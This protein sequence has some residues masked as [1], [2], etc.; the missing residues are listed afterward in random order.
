M[1]TPGIRACITRCSLGD[2]RRAFLHRVRT[3]LTHH[4]TRIKLASDC[5]AATARAYTYVTRYVRYFLK[6][7]RA[8]NVRY[9][10]VY[11]KPTRYKIIK[12]ALRIFAPWFLAFLSSFIP[13]LISAVADWMSTILLHMMWPYNI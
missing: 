6:R 9:F 4:A 13:R 8:F 12:A 3:S 10:T 2:D 7:S 1:R 11:V 5:V